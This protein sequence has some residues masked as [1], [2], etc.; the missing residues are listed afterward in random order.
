MPVPLAEGA[1]LDWIGFFLA[2]A[3]GYAFGQVRL[4]PI[5]LGGVCGTLIA[6]LLI[7]QLNISVDTGIKT[8][9]FMLF[10]FCSRL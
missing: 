1:G 7:G 8:V 4:G 5:Q 10:I 2:M 3:F 9:F 6:A